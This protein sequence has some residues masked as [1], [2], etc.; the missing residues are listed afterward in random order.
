MRFL[1]LVLL[2]FL[3]LPAGPVAAQTAPLA[4]SGPY[5]R[6]PQPY[7]ILGLS[8][9]GV[10]SENLRTFVLQA[11][12]LTVG[13]R[14]TIP[15]DP[16]LGD[17]IR[18]IYRL[19]QFSDVKIVQERLLGDGVY[20]AI[21]VSEAQRLG[22]YA[23]EG[24]KKSQRND[25]KKEVP[26]L[27]GSRVS[28]A[29]IERSKQVILDYYRGK[30]YLQAGVD[31]ERREQADGTLN[32]VFE[33]RPGRRVEVG[34]IVVAGNEQVSDRRIRKSMKET[35]ETRW[36]RF[37]SR[38]TFDRAKYEE[39][40]QKVVAYYNERG[41][42]DA[43]IVSDTVFVQNA[44]GKPEVV[45]RLE[46][47]EGPRYHVRDIRWEGNTVYP[48]EV[49][50]SALGFEEGD[51]FNSAKLEQNLFANRQ[52]TD[53]SSLYL[54]QG[55]LRFRVQ[56]N[57]R[58]VEG[59][60]LDLVLE[61]IEGEV[62]DIGDVRIVGNTKTNEHVI[63]RELYTI[64]GQTFSRQD[65][66]ESIRRLQQLNYFSQESLVQGPDVQVNEDKKTVDLTYKLEEVGSDQ[67]E[68]SGTWGQLGVVLMLRF[69]FNNFSIQNLFNGEAWRPL[70]SGDGQKLALSVQTNGRY[71]QSYSL[72]FTEPWFRGRPTPVGFSLSYS[73][74]DQSIFS[75]VNNGKFATFSGRLFY[76]QRLKWPDDKFSLST[77]L[78]YQRYDNGGG[79]TVLP[80]GISQ[81][82]TFQ[83]A[84]TRNSIDNP[85]FPRAGALT[86][87]AVDV[88]PPIP[89]FIQYHKW[90]LKSQWNVPLR[91]KVTLGV[92]A[93][94]G[95]VGSF[96]KDEVAFQR[97]V[98]GG[99]PFDTQGGY[100]YYYGRDII[101]MRGYPSGALGPRRGG[102]PVGG[103][104]LNK[105]TSEL[106]WMAVTSQQLQAAPYVFMDAANTWDGFSTYNPAQL[107]RSAGVG[108]RLFLPIIGMLEMAYGYNFD[109]FQR[110][111]NQSHDG[112]R[113]WT[114]QFSIGQGFNQ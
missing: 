96:N 95:F 113:R 108:M 44:E 56:P 114:F 55:Y 29:E 78:Q 60:S 63:R 85:L 81:E 109:E 58:V 84:L 48:D 16:A 37:W 65:I 28:Q 105:Y 104:I 8:V 64:P 100:N 13:Q 103:T 11:S 22:D 6:A 24:I 112:N 30:G 39:D 91:N 34:E 52:S 46:V 40:L 94:F 35:K 99:S 7:E 77:G 5:T 82:I 87:L 45:V 26:L 61:V 67:L 9:E 51:P 15:G 23:F 57:I 19:G 101:Y 14:V 70:P 42:Y 38:D 27:K 74:F 31:V 98:V 17:A 71:Y 66:Q 97:F 79:I 62:Y 75:T 76:D 90:Q 69:G 4:S 86:Q 43:R 89:G 50:T 1:L 3:L 102:V 2:S 41:Y 72:S 106:R 59:D 110:V 93:D 33:V 20:L 47:H 83:Q 92:T 80:D 111:A 68:L 18:A 88:A 36:W 54:N 73:R 25:L 10:E 53:V 107:Y 49:L 21:Q 12:G 32:L